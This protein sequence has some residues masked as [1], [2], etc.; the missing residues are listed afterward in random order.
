MCNM[1][2]DLGTESICQICFYVEK[3]LKFK[4]DCFS[5]AAIFYFCDSS[6]KVKYFNYEVLNNIVTAFMHPMP[7]CTMD[8][9]IYKF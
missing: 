6:N 9:I 1:H 4:Y 8:F 7:E 2:N 3:A 5:L